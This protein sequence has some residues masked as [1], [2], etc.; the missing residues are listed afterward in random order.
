MNQAKLGDD[1][2]RE[3]DM[4]TMTQTLICIPLHSRLYLVPS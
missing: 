3:G 4:T 1:W 2:D